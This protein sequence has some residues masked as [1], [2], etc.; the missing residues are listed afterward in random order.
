MLTTPH[1]SVGAWEEQG[2]RV[3]WA[4]DDAAAAAI[5]SN[6]AEVGASVAVG[7]GRVQ[8]R[9]RRVAVIDLVGDLPALQQLLPD[10][11]EYG[12]L[13]H[14]LYGVSLEKVAH[15]VDPAKNLF[16]V[17][18]GVGPVSLGELAAHDAWRRLTL[19]FREVGALVLAVVPS[20]SADLHSLLDTTDGAVV[21][22]NDV[23]V[24]PERVITIVDSPRPRSDA[25]IQLEHAAPPALDQA[26]AP[27]GGNGT[28]AP[29]RRLSI[30]AVVP[31]RPA[32]IAPRLLHQGRT[33]LRQLLADPR[34]R[35]IAAWGGG[36]AAALGAVV[37][38]VAATRDPGVPEPTGGVT[39][40]HAAGT[41]VPAAGMLGSEAPVLAVNSAVDS[42]RAAHYT[43]TLTSFTSQAGADD[44]L[45]R[46]EGRGAWAAT[47]TP[48]ILGEGA[49]WYRVTIGAYG[50]SV[51]ADSALRSLRSRNVLAPAEGYVQRSSFALLVHSSVSRDSVAGLVQGWRAK[52]LPVYALLQ[53]DGT[54]RLYAGAFE[55]PEQAG[56]LL[57]MF[58][59]AGAA[60]TVVYRIGRPL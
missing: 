5:V 15:P 51:Q 24:A 2:R 34:R 60:P 37:I 14:V 23:A 6:D 35:R 7:I 42:A 28:A 13:D 43:L 27:A 31:Q 21:V 59:T 25:G 8:A 9:R 20:G 46:E 56:W 55:T 33:M 40:A 30:A 58:K 38:A 19:G 41:T 22:G 57:S 26:A 32:V 18:S 11:A 36:I 47:Y 17:P 44:R 45:R 50:D 53:D 12:L 54:T 4:L 3:A 29:R 16:I 10:D 52:G 1:V 39:S 49:R 48:V